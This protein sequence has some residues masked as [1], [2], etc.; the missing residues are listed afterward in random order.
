M[1]LSQHGTSGTFVTWNRWSP[2]WNLSL[3]ACRRLRTHCCCQLSLRAFCELGHHGHSAWGHYHPPQR[4]PC[5]HVVVDDAP[6]MPVCASLPEDD[7]DP[8]LSLRFP[9][10]GPAGASLRPGELHV[11]SVLL[12]SFLTLLRAPSSWGNLTC[13]PSTAPCSWLSLM[14]SFCYRLNFVQASG[15]WKT[16]LVVHLA[17]PAHW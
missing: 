9:D 16:S 1:L 15:Q 6:G 5:S 10:S 17:Q 14:R 3:S 2:P 13:V 4:L 12:K 8:F 7:I 11:S